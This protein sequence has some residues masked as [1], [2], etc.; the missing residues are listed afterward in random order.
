MRGELNG[1]VGD[2]LEAVDKWVLILRRTDRQMDRQVSWSL[3]RTRRSGSRLGES[4]C[5]PSIDHRVGCF[6]TNR[7]EG[8]F[9]RFR[10]VL[11]GASTARARSLWR[12]GRARDRIA[13]VWLWGSANLTTGRV[14]ALPTPRGI[15]SGH[16]LAAVPAHVPNNTVR[17]GTVQRSRSAYP[18]QGR[19]RG[20]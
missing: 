6:G 10:G 16:F 20:E 9:L 1:V 11:V 8:A 17:S 5:H 4:V 7:C 14:R 13:V 18:L 2:Q 15:F 3:G 12:L 19:A